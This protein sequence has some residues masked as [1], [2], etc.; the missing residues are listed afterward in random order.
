MRT[1]VRLSGGR[2]AQLLLL[3][4]ATDRTERS[5]FVA[6]CFPSSGASKNSNLLNFRG[7][8]VAYARVLKAR[9]VS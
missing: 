9:G 8:A 1:Q 4:A 7:G 2:E 5:Q 3:A 6:G